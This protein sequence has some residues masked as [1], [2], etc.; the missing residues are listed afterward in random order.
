MVQSFFH[1]ELD[2][3]HTDIIP[4]VTC[5][6]NSKYYIFG[7]HNINDLTYHISISLLRICEIVKSIL[8]SV[9]VNNFNA[10]YKY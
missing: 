6:V 8:K 3:W 5:H 2:I 7:K 1:R 10:N 9:S 4:K